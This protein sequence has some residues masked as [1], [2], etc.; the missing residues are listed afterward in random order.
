MIN[1]PFTKSGDTFNLDL[2]QKLEAA[3]RELQEMVP[4][5]YLYPLVRRQDAVGLIGQDEVFIAKP[6]LGSTVGLP[7]FYY[8]RNSNGAWMYDTVSHAFHPIYMAGWWIEE[9]TQSGATFTGSRTRTG[10]GDYIPSIV[11]PSPNGYNSYTTAAAPF[12]SA[13]APFHVRSAP[14]SPDLWRNIYGLEYASA[15]IFM[16]DWAL[17]DTFTTEYDLPINLYSPSGD[18][19]P[20]SCFAYLK[21]GTGGGLFRVYFGS[22]GKANYFDNQFTANTLTQP[23]QVLT[24]WTDYHAVSPHYDGADYPTWKSEVNADSDEYF[25]SLAFTGKLWVA[26]ALF[27]ATTFDFAT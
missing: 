16:A 22:D 1:V 20:R 6:I 12:D 26:T 5:K 21:N 11:F 13:T 14:A 3:I 8:P 15:D 10:S 25:M 18:I 4:T 19:H 7:D 23:A 27:P 17:G 9:V 24:S 2:I